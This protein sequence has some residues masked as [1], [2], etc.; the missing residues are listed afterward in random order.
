MEQRQECESRLRLNAWLL[1]ILVALLL[2]A[3]LL[4]PY[5]GWLALLIGLGGALLIGFLW[6]WSHKRNLRLTREMRYGWAQ[7]GDQLVERFTLANAGRFPALWVEV[8]DHSTVPGYHVGWATGVGAGSSIRRHREA[9]CTRR[10]LFMLGPTTILTSDPF[11]IFTVSIHYPAALPFMVL[12]PIVP[13]PTIQ[14]S[15]G[16][17]TGEGRPRPNAPDRTVSASS[18]REYVPGDSTRWVHWP[19]SARQSSLFVR[20]FDGTP[21]SD[22][23]IFLDLE[24]RVQIGADQDSTEEH[25]VI[26]AASLADRGLRLRR[27]VG[28]AAHG[29]EL[30]WLPPQGGDSHRLEI[31]RALAVISPGTCSLAELLT[32]TKSSLGQHA[33]LIIVTP[34]LE[35]EWVEA[36][37]PL[38]RRGAIPTVL[39][40][41]P[42]SFGGK[43][44]VRE[45]M[46]L[47]ADLKV[48]HYVIGR[49]LL[50]LPEAHADRQGRREWR[51][52]GTGR[53]MPVRRRYDVAWKVI[54]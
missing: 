12:P 31:L 47:L 10:G 50:D 32:R 51:I 18:V 42:A 25:G 30:V 7:V 52:S 49:D 39:L 43:G 8:V 37:V 22:W 21:A 34:A 38:L 36:L 26:L 16:G 14:V 20:L 54:S 4:A 9:V 19:T 27:A 5:K 13:L 44:D 6:A 29:Q 11:G 17:R 2:V 1:P 45:T 33:S 41:D 35:S 15:P 46:A 40:L 28:L 23:W 53:A 3:Q 24:C 48:A